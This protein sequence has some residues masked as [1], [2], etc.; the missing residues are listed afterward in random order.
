M[1]EKKKLTVQE[2]LNERMKREAESLAPLIA[3]RLF[4]GHTPETVEM[5]QDEF[6]DYMERGWGDPNFRSLWLE[7][8]GPQSFCNIHDELVKR[9]GGTP[10]KEVSDVPSLPAV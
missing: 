8:V 1:G 9:Q 6:L 4:P 7:R 10:S 2:I 3:Q 5:S